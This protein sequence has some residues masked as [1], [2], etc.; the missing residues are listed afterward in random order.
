MRGGVALQ[1]VTPPSLNGVGTAVPGG[2]TRLPALTVRR[3]RLSSRAPRDGRP[4]AGT[5]NA[6]KLL[7]FEFWLLCLLA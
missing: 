4:A 1:G 6:V 2:T 5:G 7:G 3:R